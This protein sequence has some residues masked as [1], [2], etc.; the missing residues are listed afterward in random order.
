MKPAVAYIR[1]STERQGRSGLGLE[2]QQA[3]L[4]RFTEVEGFTLVQTFTETE[5]G[6]DDKRPALT[7]KRHRRERRSHRRST[8]RPGA[9]PMRV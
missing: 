6:G 7:A 9:K 2:A 3:A 1:V 8:R 5:S 4:N